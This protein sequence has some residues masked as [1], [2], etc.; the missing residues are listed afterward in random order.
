M[1]PLD[2]LPEA[3]YEDFRPGVG[4]KGARDAKGFRVGSLR[5]RFYVSWLES[6]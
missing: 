5:G 6:W 4:A 1:A 2:E 3:G